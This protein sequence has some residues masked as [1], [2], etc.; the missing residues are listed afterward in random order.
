[1]YHTS[2]RKCLVATFLDE[3]LPFLSLTNRFPEIW[4]SK[5]LMILQEPPAC[6]SCRNFRIFPDSYSK[7]VLTVEK[8]DNS[9][10]GEDKKEYHRQIFAKVALKK[11]SI[12]NTYRDTAWF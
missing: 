11:G 4:E 10:G 1:M 7:P 12:G 9:S 3:D 2:L 6:H 5:E 8:I